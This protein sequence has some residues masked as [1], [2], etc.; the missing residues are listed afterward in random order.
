MDPE[1][2]GALRDLA[3]LQQGQGQ[4]LGLGL[5]Q[6]QYSDQGSCGYRGGGKRRREELGGAEGP[7]AP[8][9]SSWRL[10]PGRER[11]VVTLQLGGATFSGVLATSEPLDV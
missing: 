4:G 8:W 11:L 1:A 3:L 7:E 10:L 2:A 9:L 6:Q 5:Y